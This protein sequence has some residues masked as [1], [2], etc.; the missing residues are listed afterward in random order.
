MIDGILQTLESTALA[1]LV[2]GDVPAYIDWEGWVFPLVETVHVLALSTVF[3]SIFMIDMRLLGLG[4]R[5]AKVSALSRAVLPWT[6]SAFA[7]A[8]VT[9]S[10]MFIS[11]ATTYFYNVPFRLKFLV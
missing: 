8:A 4:H 7:I 5:D 1:G 3:G 10:A 2:R 9:G 11:K 6:W